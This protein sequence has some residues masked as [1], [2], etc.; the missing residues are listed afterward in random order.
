VVIPDTGPDEVALTRCDCSACGV[1]PFKA[2]SALKAFPIALFLLAAA[3]ACASSHHA[4]QPPMPGTVPSTPGDV[5]VARVQSSFWGNGFQFFPNGQTRIG[6][7]IPG[8]LGKGIEGTCQTQ[9]AFTINRGRATGA[10]VTFTESWP[11]KKFRTHGP[12]RGTLHHSWHFA[13]RPNGR[14]VRLGDRGALPPQASD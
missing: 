5:A 6:C 3:S 9:V 10:L 1:V 12:P 8:P 2:V 7:R 4:A 13:V 11:A 14:V